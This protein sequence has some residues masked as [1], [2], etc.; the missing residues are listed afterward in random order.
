MSIDVDTEAKATPVLYCDIDGTIRWGK[1]EFGRFVNTVEDVHV[2]DEVSDLLHRYKKLGWRILGISNQGGIALGYMDQENCILSMVETQKQT[3]FAFDRILWC[4]HH[5][6]A[7][8]PEM[9]KC[10]CRKP[11][12]GLV[13][14]GALGLAYQFN[15]RYPP[16]LSLFVGDRPEDELCAKASGLD[17][18]SASTWRTG[19]HLDEL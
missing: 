9:A 12:S 4:P 10:W 5:P 18:M 3:N 16:Y 6:D 11:K 13:I 14:E 1:D 7:K 2:F 15:E 19:K 17:F 8:D